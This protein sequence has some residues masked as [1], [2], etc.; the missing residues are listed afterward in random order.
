[1]LLC[2]SVQSFL[3]FMVLS[4][5]VS[6]YVEFIILFQPFIFLLYSAGFFLACSVA[7]LSAV[8]FG[9]FAFPQAFNR[10][11]R[12][13]CALSLAKQSAASLSVIKYSMALR[14][15]SGCSAERSI[16]SSG[17]SRR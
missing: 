13:R 12:R 14:T 15:T 5:F 17:S 4:L 8:S 2:I 16:F 1:M 9:C 3:Y 7:I 10:W 11:C 6:F